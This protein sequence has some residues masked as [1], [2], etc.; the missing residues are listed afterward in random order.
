MQVDQI[1]TGQFSASPYIALS[2][3]ALTG[4]NYQ[5]AGCTCTYQADHKTIMTIALP[6]LLFRVFLLQS[7]QP[8]VLFFIGHHPASVDIAGGLDIEQVHRYSVV[9]QIIV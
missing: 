4:V 9:Y 2:R 7:S 6:Y 1:L 8:P 3:L 5:E